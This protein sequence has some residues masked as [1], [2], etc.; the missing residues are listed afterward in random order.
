MEIDH[1]IVSAVPLPL[2]QEGQLSVADKNMCIKYWLMT[3]NPNQAEVFKMECIKKSVLSIH[4][5]CKHSSAMVS[6][7]SDQSKCFILCFVSTVKFGL[8]R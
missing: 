2:I 4:E 8:L 5:L 1:E 7:Q 6:A 3:Q